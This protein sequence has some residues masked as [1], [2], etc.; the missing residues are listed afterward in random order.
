MG[1]SIVLSQRSLRSK[2]VPK[3]SILLKICRRT[4][5]LFV[6]GKWYKFTRIFWSLLIWKWFIGFTGQDNLTSF[7]DVRILGVLQRLAVC[8]FI[9][10]ILVLV[11]DKKDE[12]RDALKLSRGKT[13]VDFFWSTTTVSVL[14]RWR[15]GTTITRWIIQECF[16]ILDSM[17]CRDID[18]H[19]LDS[20]HFSSSR[21]QLS[22]WIYRSRRKTWSWKTSELYWR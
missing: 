14:F 16:S 4:A 9:T 21:S 6:L 10:A 17:A 20:Y 13:Y 3:L 11:L 12:G 5:I 7:H 8:Y 15:C 22:N 18:Y 1:V 19:Y 2:N